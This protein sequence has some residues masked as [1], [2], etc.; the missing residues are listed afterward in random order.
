M[1]ALSAAS[2]VATAA[3]PVPPATRWIPDNA[4]ICIELNRPTALLETLAN[5]DACKAIQ[6]LPAFQSLKASPQVGGLLTV[7]K[8]LE[9]SLETDWRTGLGT[10]TGGG[11]TFAICADGSALTII[12]S[13][14]E[15]MLNRLHE[16]LLGFAR[17]EADKAGQPGRVASAEYMGATG[18]TFN[19]KEAHAIVANRMISANRPEALKA[20]LELRNNSGGANLASR[21]DY[22]KVRKMVAPDAIGMI[23]VNMEVFRNIPG[24]A[25]A[26]DKGSQNPLAALLFAGIIDAVRNSTAMGVGLYA[27]ESTLTLEALLDG[28][29]IDPKGPAAFALPPAG[30]GAP[31]LLSAPRCIAS[32]SFHRDLHSFY[33]AKDSLFPERTGGLI[34]FENMMGIFFSGRD[35]TD[36]VLARTT[37]EVR[38]VVARQEYDPKNGTPQVQIPGFALVL[39]L[40]DT[41]AF[42]EIAEEAWQKAVG[43][44]NFTRGQQGLPGL[45]IDR[46]THNGTKFTAAYFSTAGL[47]ETT[48]LHTRFNFRPALALPADY[49]ILSTSD[50]LARDLIDAATAEASQSPKPAAGVH[51]MAQLDGGQLASILRANYD[52]LVRQNMVSKG[53]T[54]EAAE[55]TIGLLITV[56]GFVDE[57]T[58]SIGAEKELTRARLQLALNLQ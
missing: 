2:H 49:L 21:D 43:L 52:A 25:G 18:W 28:K 10:L 45:I 26:L 17:G 3:E 15:R 38:F 16:I 24:L 4:V 44:I 50:G 37:P 54:R 20:A 8:V 23:Y 34:F 19:G 12:E 41:E 6:A 31:P 47:E 58:L 56:A 57:V 22:Q 55:T 13:E 46:P 11:I 5:D 40:R 35:L 7:I 14:D 27:K 51:T 29:L 33:A 39:K 9:A 32:L 42:D 1:L 30:A 36:E 48:N 53:N